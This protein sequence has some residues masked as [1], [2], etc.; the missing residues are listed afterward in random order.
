[1]KGSTTAMVGNIAFCP[2]DAGP[3]RRKSGKGIRVSGLDE[4]LGRLAPCKG[5]KMP[6]EGCAVQTSS[7][8]RLAD[9]WGAD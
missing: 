5:L 2:I 8:L 6:A 3:T 7:L 1:M 4:G 9:H